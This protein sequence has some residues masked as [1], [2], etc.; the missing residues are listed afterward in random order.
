MS[1]FRRMNDNFIVL[2]RV[3]EI[4]DYFIKTHE[5]NF[6][7]IGSEIKLRLSEELKLALIYKFCF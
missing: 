5:M 7:E 1:L 2:K 6:D 4:F 3:S